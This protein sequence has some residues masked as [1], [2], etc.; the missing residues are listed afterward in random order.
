MPEG[1]RFADLLNLGSGLRRNDV[2]KQQATM[3]IAISARSLSTSFPPL[4]E[5]TLGA[6]RNNATG[7][8]PA[9]FVA[10]R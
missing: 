3:V 2:H 8:V 1:L 7:I 9:K 6:G 10:F 4:E 5:M